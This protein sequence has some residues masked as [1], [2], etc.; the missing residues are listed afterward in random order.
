MGELQRLE[1]IKTAQNRGGG[2]VLIAWVRLVNF[3]KSQIRL[4]PKIKKNRN[5][6]NKTKHSIHLRMTSRRYEIQTRMYTCVMVGV[7]RSF[8]FHF[9]LEICF[10]IFVDV[11]QNGIGAAIVKILLRVI[12]FVYGNRKLWSSVVEKK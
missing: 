12:F 1:K 4:S 7:E 2:G 10:V 5:N 3:T 11:L 6:K 8:N 9:F